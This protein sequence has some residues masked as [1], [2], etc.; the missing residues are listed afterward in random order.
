MPTKTPVF[1]ITYGGWYQR[2]TLHLSEIYELF[3]FG[4]SHL[5]LSLEKI[6][7]FHQLFNFVSVTR[8]AGDLEYVQAITQSGIEIR[9][10]ED[11]L[12]VLQ[13]SSSD[14]SLI[15][16]ELSLYF[17]NILNPA[18]SY[19]FSLGAPTPKILAAIKTTHPV[20]ISVKSTNVDSIL[21]S[22]DFGPSYSQITS[23]EY[24]VVKTSRY[25]I[26]IDTSKK[27]H[28]RELIEMQI[29]F[30]EFKD[31]LQRYLNIHREIWEEISEIKENGSIT[32][33]EVEPVR[34]RLDSYQKT[35]NLIRSRINQMGSYVNT[36]ASVSKKLNLEDS[37]ISIFQYK[38]ETLTDTHKYIQEIWRMTE[39]Y[40]NTAIQVV[41]EVKS[42]SADNSIQ[43]LRLITTIG[44]L[45]GIFG[46]LSKD[47]FPVVTWVGVWY[48]IVLVIGTWLINE[49]IGLIY[50][51]LRYQLKF[52]KNIG[53]K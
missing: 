44:V 25:I 23:S 14:I 6:K 38:F 40:I 9:Y 51:R 12:Y 1:T 28:T 47:K 24:N 21:K 16:K 39:D 42:R 31:Q 10:Y 29:F 27:G 34:A 43:S 8:E 33:R 41:V 50:Q 52:T 49:I 53:L 26:I 48:F 3:A 46:Y 4:R 19:I 15:Q 45:S 32:G 20:V 37:L 22:F 7:K 13:K 36:R 17:E 30:R 5:N 11:G 2:T 18:I 35:I